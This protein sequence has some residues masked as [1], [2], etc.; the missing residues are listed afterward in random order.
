LLNPE[1][2]YHGNTAI[3]KFEDRFFNNVFLNFHKKESEQFKLTYTAL[4]NIIIYQGSVKAIWKKYIE[5][6]SPIGVLRSFYNKKDDIQHG[7]LVN[8]VEYFP[9]NSKLK[10]VAL[11]EIPSDIR[12][13]NINIDILLNNI[14]KVRNRIDP[15]TG[16]YISLEY[17]IE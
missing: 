7:E 17:K 14:L 4:N 5:V 13:I 12:C 15:F 10:W 16:D 11:R 1:L 3:L 8:I 9:F 2:I 6:F